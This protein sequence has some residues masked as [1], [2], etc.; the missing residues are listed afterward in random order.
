VILI[1]ECAGYVSIQQSDTASLPNSTYM[2]VPLV[3]DASPA[4]FS[5]VSGFL[6]LPNMTEQFLQQF[7]PNYNISN[8]HIIIVDFYSGFLPP[9]QERKLVTNFRRFKPVAII[10]MGGTLEIPP[11]SCILYLNTALFIL[12]NIMKGR[13][14]RLVERSSIGCQYQPPR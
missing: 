14:R 1:S 7:P 12:Q 5:P 2:S 6:L 13:I 9:Y 4:R 11:S 8:I 3:Y 10:I